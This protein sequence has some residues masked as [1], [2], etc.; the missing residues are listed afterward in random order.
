MRVF[1][2]ARPMVTQPDPGVTV[3]AVTS[4]ATSDDP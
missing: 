3:P 4:P 1:A 2:I